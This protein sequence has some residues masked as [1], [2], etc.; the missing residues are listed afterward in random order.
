M[1]QLNGTQKHLVIS[2]DQRM[3]QVVING[4]QAICSAFIFSIYYHWVAG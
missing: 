4:Y 3:G 1:E 2:V